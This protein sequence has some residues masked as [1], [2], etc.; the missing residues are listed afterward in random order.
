MLKIQKKGKK[1]HVIKLNRKHI[2][3][4]FLIIMKY[5]AVLIYNCKRTIKQQ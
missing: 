4:F 2:E 1:S 3:S 5:Y